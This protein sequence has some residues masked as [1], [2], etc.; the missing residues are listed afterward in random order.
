MIKKLLITNSSEIAIRIIRA[1]QEL[2]IEAVA[3]YSDADINALHVRLADSAC[4]I[5]PADPLPYIVI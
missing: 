2:G 4:R 5:G 3:V 1:C